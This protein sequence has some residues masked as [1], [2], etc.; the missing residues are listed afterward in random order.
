MVYYLNE[1][2][3]KFLTF[4]LR[5]TA[6]L[7][8]VPEELRGWNWHSP[9]LK[10]YYDVKLP[11]Y[12]ICSNYCPTSRDCYLTIVK[13]LR[14]EENFWIKLGKAIHDAVA[15]AIREA[16]RLRFDS[17]PKMD[18]NEAIDRAVKLIWDFTISA[19]KSAYLRAKAEQPYANEDDVILTSIP[20]FVE[21]RMDGSML[22]CS[23]LISVDCYDYLRNIVFDLKL[24]E[25]SE[26]SKLY[27]TGYALVLESIYEIPVDIGCSVNVTFYEDRL[28]VVKNLYYIDANLRSWWIEERDRKAEIIYR[29][30]DPGKAENCSSSCIFKAFCL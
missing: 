25:F 20:F 6:R 26:R 4:T 15:N 9:P 7:N 29:E 30:K 21:H 8:P 14:G 12:L 10:P 5:Q 27:T 1:I 28:G 17:S 19:C 3:Q 11:M 16:R 24:G 22:G 13:K 18:G 23:G 2:E